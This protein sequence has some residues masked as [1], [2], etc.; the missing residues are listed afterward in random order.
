M[1]ETVLI[2]DDSATDIRLMSQY[3]GEA[4]YKT[5]ISTTADDA[6]RIARAKQPDVILM[7]VILPGTNGFKATRILRDD[8]DTSGIPVIIVS[9]R[10]QASDRVWGIRQGASDYITKPINRK[11]LLQKLASVI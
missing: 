6:I 4:G 10:T 8:P 11:V 2:V 1:H 9:S 3:L 5:L 7:D